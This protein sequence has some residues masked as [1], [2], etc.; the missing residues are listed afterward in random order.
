M[1]SSFARQMTTDIREVSSSR[2]CK[3]KQQ[4]DKSKDNL[5]FLFSRS[6]PLTSTA[7][8]RMVHT[9]SLIDQSYIVNT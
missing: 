8:I 3:I 2:L 1:R 5:L 6:Y 7:I 4:I 9:Y